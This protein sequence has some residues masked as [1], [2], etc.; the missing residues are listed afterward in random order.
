MAL[1]RLT[2]L[3]CIIAFVA[4]TPIT[5]TQFVASAT[6]TH[7]AA[8]NPNAYPVLMLLG[9]VAHGARAQMLVAPNATFETSFP[10]G[11]LEDIYIEIVFFAPTG[12]RSSGAVS[13]DTMILAQ[14]EFLEVQD[15]GDEFQ[16]WIYTNGG[17]LPADSGLNLA[18]PSLMNS[19][20]TSTEPLMLDPSHVPVIT[21][22]DIYDN[23]VAPKIKGTNPSV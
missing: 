11:T 20:A 9:D 7:F 22:Q 5:E 3:L 13:F 16:P 17:R 19:T 18:P 10:T 4:A 15:N 1:A 6:P 12:R 14:A 21:T 23:T 8:T 2:P